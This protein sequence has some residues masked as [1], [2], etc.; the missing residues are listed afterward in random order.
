MN[1]CD[2]FD[3]P[4]CNISNEANWNALSGNGRRSVAITA[5]SIIFDKRG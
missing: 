3:R 4:K 2:Y 5:P 1:P